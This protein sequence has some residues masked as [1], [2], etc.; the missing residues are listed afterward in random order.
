MSDIKKVLNF[1]C[2][3]CG[4]RYNLEELKEEGYVDITSVGTVV[5]CKNVKC[6]MQQLVKDVE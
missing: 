1:C 3:Y 5:T 4:K 2:D 6:E